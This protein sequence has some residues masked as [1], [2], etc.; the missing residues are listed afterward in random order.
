[1]RITG[2]K[3]MISRTTCYFLFLVLVLSLAAGCSSKD[4]RR[5]YYDSKEMSPLN[6]PEEL[7]E[8]SSASALVI[9]LSSVVLSASAMD[10]T[11]PRISSTTSGIDENSSLNWSAQGMYLLVQ[12]T[13]ESAE[14]R[15]G[16][17]IER[18]GMSNIR[19]DQEG[20]Y[21]FDYR[22]EPKK[23]KRG[24]FKSLVFWRREKPQDYSGTYQVY[25]RPDGENT[26]IY[27]KYA[28]GNACEPEVA[29]HVL[30]VLGARLG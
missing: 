5:E 26:R 28:D 2:C 19:K 12:D 8:P 1:M 3:K 15:L 17:V 21:R 29:E 16:I 7:N 14:R 20:V 13:R 4:K 25:S 9:P 11:P 10:P 6:V 22:H 24:F 23:I 18:S 27:I 30:A